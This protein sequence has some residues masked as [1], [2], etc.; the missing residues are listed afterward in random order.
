MPQRR[1]GTYQMAQRPDG[2][3]APGQLRHHRGINMDSCAKPTGCNRK[4]QDQA[5]ISKYMK[6][7]IGLASRYVLKY[8]LIAK[9]KRVFRTWESL[10]GAPPS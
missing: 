4:T 10:A 3:G 7:G 1:T 5:D 8:V 2:R 9:R 6:Q